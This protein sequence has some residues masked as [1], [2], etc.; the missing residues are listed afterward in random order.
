[1]VGTATQQKQHD[2]ENWYQYAMLA[3]VCWDTTYAKNFWSN[4]QRQG[5]EKWETERNK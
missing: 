2:P 5:G 1:M 4:F 3:A